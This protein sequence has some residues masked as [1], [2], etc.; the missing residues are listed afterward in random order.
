[1]KRL[2]GKSRGRHRRVQGHRGR[3]RRAPGR[4][5]GGGRRQLRLQQGRGRPGRRRDHA[6][7]RQGRRRAGQR[8]RS[9]PTS[10][11]CSP[12][13]RRPSA[14]LDILVN[15]AG[16]YEF[17]PLEAS[18]RRALPQAVRPERAGP[19]PGHAGS[20]QALRPRRRQHH[21]HQLGRRDARRLPNASVYSATK[22]A[23]DAIT[24]SL[25]KEL[26]PR[27]IRVNSIN[28]GMVET[29]GVHAAGHR[30]ERLPQAGRSPDA[31][32]PHRPAAGHRPGG[33]LPGLRRFRPGSPAKRSTS[34][35]ESA[36]SIP[37]SSCKMSTARPD[38][39]YSLDRTA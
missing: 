11:G 9:R 29:E 28:P 22:A 32:R 33:R 36:E 24:R 12:R 30:R 23:V 5:R 13:R 6:Q 37:T 4:G 21:Q 3:H 34:P 19:A 26:G 17:A 7:G 20:R 38:P 8:R 25:A 27:K 39:A 31:A 18:H 14:E 15:N 35:A 16:I 2:N 10:S 1:M